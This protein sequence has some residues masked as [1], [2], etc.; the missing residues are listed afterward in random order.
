MW[1]RLNWTTIKDCIFLFVCLYAV[2]YVF[3][4]A[5]IGNNPVLPVT[6]N[7]TQL[8]YFILF[9]LIWVTTVFDYTEPTILMLETGMQQVFALSR[10]YNT[11]FRK[12]CWKQQLTKHCVNLGYPKLYDFKRCDLGGG[13]WFR[14][15]PLLVILFFPHKN[16]AQ[17]AMMTPHYPPSWPRDHFVWEMYLIR[18][19]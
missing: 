2:C 1:F 10:E 13:G 8:L 17:R 7:D 4:A 19:I 9:H 11:I 15:C 18:F 5:T 6:V 14:K 3:R 12:G 16:F